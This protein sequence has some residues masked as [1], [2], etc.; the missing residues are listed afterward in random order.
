MASR[1]LNSWKTWIGISLV[2]ACALTGF[3]Q[4]PR[5]AIIPIDENTIRAHIK[6]LSSDLLE[7]RGTGARGGEI[8][9]NYIA[10]QLEAW[11]LKGAGPQGSFLQQVSL[12][13]VK[14]D[15]ATKLT[16]TSHSNK[17]TFK[18]ADDY[19]AFTGAQTDEV[20]VDTDLVFVGYGINAPE[21]KWNDYKGEPS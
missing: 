17:E 4:R 12:V 21:Q 16:I 18:F 8:A 3:S 11:G 15:P 20:N 2:G 6:F 1:P 10:A 19:V 5:A 13:G 7:G 9:A 14:A